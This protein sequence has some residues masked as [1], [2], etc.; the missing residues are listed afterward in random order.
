MTMLLIS[1]VVACASGELQM[2]QQCTK[3][4]PNMGKD[5]NHCAFIDYLM[6]KKPL[7]NDF[8]PTETRPVSTASVR[9]DCETKNGMNLAPRHKKCDKTK[10]TE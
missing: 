2:L 6:S 4:G 1:S 3:I 10:A 7:F 9:K 8:W 5:Q